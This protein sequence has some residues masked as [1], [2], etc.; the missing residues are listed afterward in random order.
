MIATSRLTT[1]PNFTM[2][3]GTETVVTIGK[4]MIRYWTF[5]ANNKAQPLSG[6]NATL[7]ERRQATFIDCCQ[8]KT[9]IFAVAKE[10]S[11]KYRTIS[12]SLSPF[13]VCYIFDRELA[14]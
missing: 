1:E 3:F 13:A 11:Q 14:N 9:A 10:V 4:G 12:D 7:K 5:P 8:T 2:F 6:R